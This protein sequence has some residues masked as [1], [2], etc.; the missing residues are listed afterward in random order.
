MPP[1]HCARP[2]EGPPHMPLVE[3]AHR[4]RIRS[5]LVTFP[6]YQ[7]STDP[8]KTLTVWYHPEAFAEVQDQITDEIAAT[9]AE[10]EAVDADDRLSSADRRSQ[11][12]DIRRRS[13]DTL[14]SLFGSVLTDWDMYDDAEQQ[15][16]TPIT[17]ETFDRLQ[18]TLT[19][20]V[21]AIG[22]YQTS[23][24]RSPSRVSNGRSSRN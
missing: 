3:S 16:K 9:A 6:E 24:N 21:E 4:T 23:P 14:F 10:I 1:V 11:I 8:D 19:R 2:K 13:T 17:P 22:E 18:A 20:I 7:H 5:V 15:H 12:R